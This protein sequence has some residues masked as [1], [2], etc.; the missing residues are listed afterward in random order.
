MRRGEVEI[1][2]NIFK[3][4]FF[5]DFDETK[6]CLHFWWVRLRFLKCICL[7]FALFTT[8]EIMLSNTHQ[9]EYETV[10]LVH[11]RTRKNWQF[12][13]C[14]KQS[15]R[16]QRQNTMLKECFTPRTVFTSR[17]VSTSRWFLIC[18]FSALCFSLKFQKKILQGGRGNIYFRMKRREVVLDWYLSQSV[19]SE[20]PVIASKNFNRKL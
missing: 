13:P 5:S 6:Y 11:K 20:K 4:D 10:S 3:N 8:S 15:G 17:T 7:Q 16:P 1:E 19:R 2:R 14:L 9:A 18:L 12:F